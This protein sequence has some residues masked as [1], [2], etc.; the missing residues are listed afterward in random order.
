MH[1]IKPL[2]LVI[3]HFIMLCA[4]CM[5]E[6]LGLPDVLGLY[7]GTRTYRY[8][9]PETFTIEFTSIDENG[10]S[11]VTTYKNDTQRYRC[12]FSGEWSEEGDAVNIDFC[13]D[14]VL[15]KSNYNSRAL[16]CVKGSITG[17]QM[18]GHVYFYSNSNPCG[19]FSL[20]RVSPTIEQP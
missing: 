3:I 2:V 4:C 16:M 18:S 6:D 1:T 14:A 7:S 12:S 5:I 19:S 17:E 15:E 10:I 8:F 9:Y 13:E 11:G 20:K